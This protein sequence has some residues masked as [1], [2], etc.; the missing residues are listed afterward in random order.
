MS[1]RCAGVGWGLLE[2]ESSHARTTPVQAT[3][4]TGVSQVPEA[5]VHRPLAQPGVGLEVG[6]K[7][8]A[9]P[10]LG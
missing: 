10:V 8:L 1:K 3:A 4:S 9:G 6:R 2:K 5:G 7:S